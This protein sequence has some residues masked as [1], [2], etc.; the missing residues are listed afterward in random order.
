MYVP[1]HTTNIEVYKRFRRPMGIFP[2]KNEA[3]NISLY[4][5]KPQFTIFSSDKSTL[6]VLQ[7]DYSY[8]ALLLNNNM[9][10]Y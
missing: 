6:V 3:I 5:Q 10:S 2:W 8:K 9:M 4:I 7:C 1:I